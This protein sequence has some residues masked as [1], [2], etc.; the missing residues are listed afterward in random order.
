[1]ELAF[2]NKNKTTQVKYNNGVIDNLY[3]KLDEHE[4]KT[5]EIY[6]KS[7]FPNYD[8]FNSA[9]EFLNHAN[10]N[11][12][13]RS[14]IYSINTKC[15]RSHNNKVKILEIGCSTGHL[16]NLLSL[17]T[18]SEVVGLDINLNSL[19]IAKIFAEKN[20]IKNIN[21]VRDN[22]LNHCLE[23]N[24]FDLIII[25]EALNHT[26]EIYKAFVESVKLCKKNGYIIV[27]LPNSFR[28]LSLKIIKKLVNIFGMK[29]LNQQKNPRMKDIMEWFEVND[30]EYLFSIPFPETKFENTN[31]IIF[32][33]HN[34]PPNEFLFIEDLKIFLNKAKENGF[35]MIGK[36]N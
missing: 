10:T 34:K 24:Y 28:I 1:M 4:K 20:N 14:L 12:Y 26:R 18:D 29:S 21:F 27:N 17:V 6:D 22:I 8:N 25:N 33:K 11:N 7:S 3:L 23:N 9:S 36:K 31:K 35:I 19:L 5:S 13:I 32:D 2:L 30:I 15:K 16:A